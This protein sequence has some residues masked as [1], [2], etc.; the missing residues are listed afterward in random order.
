MQAPPPPRPKKRVNV[1]PAVNVQAPLTQTEQPQWIYQEWMHKGYKSSD[2]WKNPGEH[3]FVARDLLKKY[4]QNAGDISKEYNCVSGIEQLKKNLELI[5][6]Q[7]RCVYEQFHDQQRVKLFFDFEIKGPFQNPVD[8]SSNSSELNEDFVQVNNNSIIRPSDEDI[9]NRLDHICD[10]AIRKIK[11]VYNIEIDKD[12][13]A[14][15]NSSNVNKISYHVILTKGIYFT[16]CVELKKFFGDHLFP[17]EYLNNPVQYPDFVGL[18][19]VVYGNGR[20]FRLPTCTKLGEVR[21]LVLDDRYP[22]EDQVVVY[23]PLEKGRVVDNVTLKKTRNKNSKRKADEML[24]ND[25]SVKIAG[26]MTEE[27]ESLLLKIPAKEA[28][29]YNFWINTGIKFKRAGGDFEGWRKWTDRY[30]EWKGE[31]SNREGKLESRWSGFDDS[32]DLHLFLAHVRMYAKNEAGESIGT[33]LVKNYVKTSLQYVGVLH[34]EIGDAFHIRHDMHAYSNGCWYYFNNTRWK[35]DFDGMW[36]SRNIL[37]W[38]NELNRRITENKQELEKLGITDEDDDEIDK[39]FETQSNDG[40][41]NAVDGENAEKCKEIIKFN[42][43][44][45]LIKKITQDGTIGNNNALKAIYFNETFYDELDSYPDLI[46]FNNGL[47]DLTKTDEIEENMNESEIFELVFRASSADDK[48]TLSTGYDINIKD[49]DFIDKFENAKRE[50][51]RLFERVYPDVSVR[52][53]VLRFHSS[54]LTARC[55]DEC[56]HFY[57]GMNSAQTGANAKSTIDLLNLKVLGEYAVVGHPSLLTNGRES[58]NSANSALMAIKNKR[59]VSFQEINDPGNGKVTLN[60]QIIKN[61]TGGDQQT[62]RDLHERQSRPFDQTWKIVVSANKLPPMSNDDG[63]SRRR[64]RDIP[65]EAKFVKNPNDPKYTG[66]KYVF[67]ADTSLKDRIKDKEKKDNSLILAY[68]YL[69]IREHQKWRQDGLLVCDRVEAHTLAY[70]N[71]QDIF[72]SWMEE[73]V[74]Y[75]GRPEDTIERSIMEATFMTVRTS[76]QTDQQIRNIRNKETFISELSL[77]QRMGPL[78]EFNLWVGWKYTNDQ[79]LTGILRNRKTSPSFNKNN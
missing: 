2:Q 21:P 50:I 34:N 4:G 65:H 51:N 11:E 1:Q 53:Y 55:P 16:N 75:T 57:T 30:F 12:W 25:D 69:L 29:D 48:I 59:Y 38:H 6:Q 31:Q 62:G 64:V 28:D 76:N 70:L 32:Y 3:I 60:M 40:N 35:K 43:K 66:M 73:F 41:I 14:F 10:R 58:A 23:C 42:K 79:Y 39:K 24:V 15:M 71:D 56:I 26:K 49:K 27:L 77:P 22:F 52:K 33:E 78:N 17:K 20:L 61:L 13:F 54:I 19:P 9:E 18:D 68:L 8:S 5:P 74:R 67:E 47:I 7:E 72:R 63:G 44:L 37:S 45:R 36:L 46:G